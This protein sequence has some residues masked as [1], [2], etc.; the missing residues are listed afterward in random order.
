MQNHPQDREL[1]Q[2]VYDGLKYLSTEWQ[3]D[4]DDSLLRITS[5]ILRTLLIDGKLK[6]AADTV[7]LRTRIMAPSIYK[8]LPISELKSYSYWQC[9]GAK[10]RGTMVMASGMKNYAMTAEEMKAEFEKMKPTIGK[11]FPVKIDQFLKQISF[12]V[13]GVTISRSTVIKYVCNKLGGTHYDSSRD[14]GNEEIEAQFVLL[15]KIRKQIALADKNAIYFELLSIGQRI[16]NSRDIRHLQRR[17]KN[18][19]GAPQIIHA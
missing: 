19:L 15:D 1:L 7:Q 6:L 14:Y 2:V 16:V 13:E 10:H 17:L 12:V 3:Q 4:I 8:T 18:I 9:G 5:P 11:S